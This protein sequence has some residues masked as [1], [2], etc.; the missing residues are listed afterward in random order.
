[1]PG[2]RR[3]RRNSVAATPVPVS[4]PP[5]V[6]SRFAQRCR[7]GHGPSQSPRARGRRGLGQP[8]RVPP[9][10]VTVR[11][12][13]AAAGPAGAGEPELLLRRRGSLALAVSVQVVSTVTFK[14]PGSESGGSG[15]V[16]QPEVRA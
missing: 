14:L 6:V 16:S 5:P 13:F 2:S 9:G 4:E 15:R 7:A 3:Q 8:G 1:M 10:G 12:G 11:P